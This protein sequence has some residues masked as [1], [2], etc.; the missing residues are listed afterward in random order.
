MPVVRWSFSGVGTGQFEP[1]PDGVSLPYYISK[2]EMKNSKK[3]NP[4][5]VFEFTSADPESNR[6]AW[7]NFSLLQQ[8]LWGLKGFL[9]DIGVDEDEL[10][11]DFEFDSDEFINTEVY[12]S[13]NAPEDW[14][15]KQVQNIES[16]TVR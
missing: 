12:L 2:I 8:A 14:E 5:V 7:K 4:M 1:V 13:F 6:K 16:V 3:G 9:M 11:G 15:G 10:I